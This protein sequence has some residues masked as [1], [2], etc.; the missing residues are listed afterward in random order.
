MRIDNKLGIVGAAG[1]APRRAAADGFS[2]PADK[3]GPAAGS[4]A[5]TAGLG[6]I[7]ALLALQGEEDPIRRRKRAIGRGRDMLDALDGLKASL[8]GGPIA[9]TD[10]TRL[11]AILTESRQ[12]TDDPG[13]DDVLAH[14]ELRAEVELAKL[15]RRS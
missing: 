5:G 11:R 13:L 1:G 12:A 14:I 3:A 9:G 8:L 15:A 10:L 2:L 7:E 6:G 4:I